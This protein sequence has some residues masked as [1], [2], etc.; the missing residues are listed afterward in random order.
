[1][2]GT[3][4]PVADYLSKAKFH[5]AMRAAVLQNTDGSRG[6]AKQDQIGGV[7]PDRNRPTPEL[8]GGQNG[9]PVIEYSHEARSWF[10]ACASLFGIRPQLIVRCGTTSI[11]IAAASMATAPKC[12]A[13]KRNRR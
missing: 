3:L 4:E 9:V 5:A 11:I 12:F 8:F 6:G 1:M 10:G 2:V 13:R 7:K